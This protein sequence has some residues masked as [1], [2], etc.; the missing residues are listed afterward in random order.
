MYIL[1]EYT[2]SCIHYFIYNL[3]LLCLSLITYILIRLNSFNMFM[4]FSIHQYVL[5]SRTITHKQANDDFDMN[6]NHPGT[7]PRV[8]TY[9]S[10]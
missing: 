7:N 6:A 9:N 10:I 4:F 1:I 5:Q 2:I 3:L 8:I